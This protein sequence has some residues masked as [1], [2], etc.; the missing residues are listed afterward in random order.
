LALGC[1]T[2]VKVRHVRND[3]LW[4]DRRGNVLTTARL[5]FRSRQLLR[6][7]DLDAAFRRDPDNTIQ[8]LDRM[9]RQH[10]DADMVFTLSELCYLTAQQRERLNKS[11]AMRMYLGAVAYAYFYLFDPSVT[12]PL[13]PFDPRFRLACDLYN[14]ALAKCI[15]LAQ[16]RSLKLDD[17]LRLD[18]VQ[19][20]IDIKVTRYGFVWEPED[21]GHFEFAAD[22]GV[23][24]LANHYH[25]YGLGVPLIAVRSSRDRDPQFHRYQP[26]EASFPVTA[27]LR[28]NCNLCDPETRWRQA[29][30]EL[31]DPLRIQ[32]VAVAD[33]RVPLES[34]LTTPLGYYLARAQLEK[35]E[36]GGL[37]RPDSVQDKAGL[38]LLE[39]Y[40]PGKIPVVLI[41]GLWSSPLFAMPM[42][43]DLRGD[44]ELRR[45]FQFWFFVYPTGTP[46]LHSADLLRRS[47]IEARKSCDPAGVDPAMNQMVLIGHSMGGLLAKLMAQRSGPELWQLV[48]TKPAEQLKVPE[49]TRQRLRE[50][51]LFEPLPAVQRIIFIAT[52]HR[53]SAISSR[54]IGRLGSALISLPSALVEMHRTLLAGD[55]EAVA[56]LLRRGLPTSIDNLSPDSPTI[57]ALSRLPIDPGVR[58]HSI[59]GN[60]GK[61]DGTRTDGIVDYESA[62][63][64]NAE[65]ELVV[66]AGHSACQSHPLTVLEIRRILID[67]LRQPSAASSSAS[68]STTD[69]PS[70][71]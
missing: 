54:P 5:S 66:P 71:R 13:N 25:T 30:L 3:W 69:A 32:T 38:Y 29:T 16:R 23:D 46:L 31:Y 7:Y 26:K 53:G 58:C 14:Q 49:E 15:R 24:G 12:S 52:P 50:I 55:P 68:Q 35:L 44:S 65:T 51:Y 70:K 41:H 33:A 22:F 11:E 1:S 27:F 61:R 34:D 63:F 28:M 67:H 57:D 60:I 17:T 45:R 62:H 18:F 19:G 21:F 42:F 40:E 43:N 20:A 39:P 4:H 6:R 56:P 48:S 64:A 2:G 59:I 47:L 10:P 8:S 37:L 36:L 9:V